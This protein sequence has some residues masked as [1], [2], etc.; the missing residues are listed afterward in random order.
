MVNK[1]GNSDE[2]AKGRKFWAY[3]I[4]QIL[5]TFI[6]GILTLK[7]GPADL[8]LLGQFY[9]GFQGLLTGGYIGFNVLQKKVTVPKNG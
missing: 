6:T 3:V 7:V 8:I 4:S 9:I 2:K 5:T 1:M